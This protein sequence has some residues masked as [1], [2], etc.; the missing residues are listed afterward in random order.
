MT[1]PAGGGAN[2]RRVR[3]LCGSSAQGTMAFPN[4]PAVPAA[5]RA[6]DGDRLTERATE[7]KV[8]HALGATRWDCTAQAV[9]CGSSIA[10]V[11]G[12]SIAR[13]KTD[14]DPGTL[15]FHGWRAI[16]SFARRMSRAEPGELR[17][18][19]TR[20]TDDGASRHLRPAYRRH[21]RRSR[22]PRLP[23]QYTHRRDP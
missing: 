2:C 18:H 13:G 23:H 19:D 3:P 4:R 11:V 7:A 16:L 21:L 20:R 9:R 22:R 14:D 17:A 6:A 10:V 1:S 12:E 8:S 5:G 15:T